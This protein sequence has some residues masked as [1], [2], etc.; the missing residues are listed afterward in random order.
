MKKMKKLIGGF[1]IM[2]IFAF[3]A[4]TNSKKTS[5]ESVST[6]PTAVE[7]ID[8]NDITK[9][10]EYVEGITL[11][12]KSDCATCHRRDEKIQGPSYADIA[13]KYPNDAKSLAI[14]SGKIIKG[15]KGVW[16]D[17]AMLPHPNLTQDEAEKLVK[18]IMLFK[19]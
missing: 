7:V 13:A 8:P 3:A 2:G 17:I 4:C 18:Y 14:L 15:G 9:K 16:G 6:T 1:M 11:V 12:G 10:P 19:K 5:D